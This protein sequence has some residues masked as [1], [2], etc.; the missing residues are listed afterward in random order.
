MM[1]TILVKGVPEDLLKELKRLK[2]EMNCR[3]WAELFG[4]LVKSERTI[5]PSQSEVMKMADGV[6]GFL[7]LEHVVSKGWAGSPAVLEEFRKSR[8]HASR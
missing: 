1:A 7:K 2:V 4:E 5:V 3:T 6:R 8:G